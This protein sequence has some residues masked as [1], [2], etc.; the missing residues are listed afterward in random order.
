MQI[1]N[2]S[3]KL[4]KATI[5]ALSALTCFSVIAAVGALAPKADEGQ[6]DPQTEVSAVSPSSLW[7]PANGITVSDDGD[8]PTWAKNGW[9]VHKADWVSVAEEY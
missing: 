1:K 2:L 7:T 6:V 4:K 9:R 8:V 3:K 5:C